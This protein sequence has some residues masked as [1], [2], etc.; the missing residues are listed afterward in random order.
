MVHRVVLDRELL[1]VDHHHRERIAHRHRRRRRVR[2]RHAERTRLLA[3][4]NL[5]VDIAHLR[6]RRV[7]A[8]SHRNDLEPVTAD[9]G[10]QVVDLGRLAGEA[11]RDKDVLRGDHAEVAVHRLHGIEDDRARTS[12]REDGAH[13]LGDVEVLADAGDDDNAAV[14]DSVENEPD[15]LDK[16]CTERVAGLLETLDLNCEDL[17]RALDHLVV[18]HFV[19]D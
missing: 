1:R 19:V 13:L 16:R 4:R 11:K 10:N 14:R 15:R 12:R 8:A 2:R 9:R 5:D 6:K 3:A 17:L 18:C 7:G